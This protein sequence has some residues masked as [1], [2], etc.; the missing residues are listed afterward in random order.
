MKQQFE[1]NA[2]VCCPLA[3]VCRMTTPDLTEPKEVQ[4]LKLQV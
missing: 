4:D 2:V 1:E 3:W